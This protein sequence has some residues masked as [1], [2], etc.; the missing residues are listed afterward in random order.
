MIGDAITK[1]CK[2]T[3]SKTL[4]GVSVQ[5]GSEI[6]RHL[7]EERLYSLFVYIDK[8]L[9]LLNQYVDR[10]FESNLKLLHPA[11]FSLN[12]SEVDT[13]YDAKDSIAPTLKATP[14]RKDTKI[15]KAEREQAFL[16]PVI[17]YQKPP[18]LINLLW[19]EILKFCSSLLDSLVS[20]TL[21][22]TEVQIVKIVDIIVELLKTIFYCKVPKSKGSKK[23]ENLG[24]SLKALE[25][26]SYHQLRANLES[27][28][29][30][31]NE[32]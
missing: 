25:T 5:K 26:F 29:S 12:S 9:S 14:T 7:V 8:T 19:H 28:L 20:E 13:S 10:R 2:E 18:A 23:K 15:E 4:F 11:A 24:L 17:D 27:L 3:G 21:S 16:D 6:S 22:E 31:K 32:L 1:I 30:Q